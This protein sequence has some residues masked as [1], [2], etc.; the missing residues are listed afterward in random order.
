MPLWPLVARL[1]QDRSMESTEVSLRPPRHVV[2]AR[3]PAYWAVRAL[4]GWLIP[5][6]VE[7]IWMLADGSSRSPHVVGLVATVVVAAAHVTIMPMWR[8]PVPRG[9]G[10]PQ[11]PPTPS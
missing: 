3:A 11:G 8:V 9:G 1:C 4:A 7:I 5:L 2:S 6:T 10:A